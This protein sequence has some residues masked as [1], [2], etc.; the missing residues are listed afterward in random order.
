MSESYD[1]Y[2][3]VEIIR[4]KEDYERGDL[5][6]R[7][8]M[9]GLLAVGLSVSSAGV[10]VA[11]ARDVNPA[12]PKR[13][14]FGVASPGICM[15]RTTPWTRLNSYQFSTTYVG[16]LITTAWCVLMTTLPFPPSSPKSGALM[17]R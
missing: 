11:G 6:R 5:T 7:E 4:M 17:P 15:A 12:T 3:A 9:Q 10:L 13:G 2:Q 1:G 16:V 8:F 14:G